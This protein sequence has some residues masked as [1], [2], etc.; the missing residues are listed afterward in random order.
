[1]PGHLRIPDQSAGV[2]PLELFQFVRMMLEIRSP[3]RIRTGGS[4]SA[5][6]TPNE[7]KAIVDRTGPDGVRK[8]YKDPY[9]L[10]ASALAVPSTAD[11]LY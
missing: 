3:I 9:P 10:I 11:A 8:W 2:L 7:T 5:R 1:M 4:P 6:K